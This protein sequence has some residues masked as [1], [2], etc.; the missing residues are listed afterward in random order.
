MSEQ[1]GSSTNQPFKT[2]GVHLKYLREQAH[3]SRAEVSGAVEIDEQALERME[4]GIERP[5][6]DIL[7]LLINYFNMQDQ[8][9]VQLWEMAGY[10]GNPQDL[11][12]GESDSND[13]QAPAANSKTTLVFMA[14]E[15]RTMYSDGLT[16]DCGKTGLTLTFTQGDGSQPAPI[17]KVGMSYEQLEL[18]LQQLQRSLLHGKYNREPKK[19]PPT[20][21]HHESQE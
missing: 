12:P 1:N 17:S 21:N 2:L 14:F 8:E 7:L 5:A 9:A 18:V 3:Q 11:Q 10:E 16:I 4:K 13:S 19:L 6:E 20:S 15:A